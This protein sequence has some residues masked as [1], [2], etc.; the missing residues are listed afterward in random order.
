MR[1][2]VEYRDVS[3]PSKGTGHFFE[4]LSDGSGHSLIYV[5]FLLK[6]VLGPIMNLHIYL[7]SRRHA[8]AST[9]IGN[10]NKREKGPK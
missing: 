6:A 4:T 10:T 9:A 2:V 8:Y 5:F 7:C 3:I 1:D